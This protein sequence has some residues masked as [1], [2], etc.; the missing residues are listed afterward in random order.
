MAVGNTYIIYLDCNKAF[1]M[2]SHYYLLVEMKNLGIFLNYVYY[3]IL[4][5]RTMKV[6]IGN[7]Y[8]ETQN[9]PS[10]VPQGSVLRP[11]LFLIFINDLSNDI[12]IRNKTIH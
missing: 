11:L 6:K 7:N 9:I 12:Y 10:N 1:D 8:S 2:I 3:K 4:I 5:K